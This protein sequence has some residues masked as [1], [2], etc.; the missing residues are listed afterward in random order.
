MRVRLIR[1]T[2][3]T[4]ADLHTRL[5]AEQREFYIGLWMEADDAGYVA[6]DLDRVGADLYPF[7]PLAWRR[8]H[9]PEWL[10]LLG[11]HAVLLDCGK[12]VL[13]PALSRHQSPPKPSY[14][15]QRAHGTCGDQVVPDGASGDQRAPAQGVSKEGGSL[16]REGGRPAATPKPKNGDDPV[17]ETL[18]GVYGGNPSKAVMEWGDRLANEYGAEAAARAIG[19]AATTGR[20][21]LMSRAEG[22][23]KLVARAADR[24]EEAEERERLRQKRATRLPATIVDPA[25]E[26]VSEI[27]ENIAKSLGT[28]R[29]EAQ[30]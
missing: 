4:D 27:M 22:S 30:A 14:Q 9:L 12:H 23:L 13:I 29:K 1:P 15:N 21:K 20:E 16:G 2:Y 8:E 3:W 24:T 19:E 5:T 28:H 26:K 6:W 18:F 11:E 7:E 17:A 10:T 25:P